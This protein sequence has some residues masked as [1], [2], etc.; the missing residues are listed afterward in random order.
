MTPS[1]GLSLTYMV[2]TM[3]SNTGAEAEKH[4]FYI[5][6]DCMIV[7]TNSCLPLTLPQTPWAICSE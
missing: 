4:Y 1:P 2:I 5:T 7:A 6:R 3:M